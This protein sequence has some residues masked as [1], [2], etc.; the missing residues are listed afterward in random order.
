MITYLTTLPSPVGTLTL[1]AD[2]TALTGLW[3]EGQKYFGAGLPDTIQEKDLSVFRE[4]EA[5]LKAYFAKAPLP[6]LPPLAP[7]GSSFRQA[8]WQLLLEI[9]YGTVTTYGALAQKLRDRGISA[10]AQAVGGAVGHNPISILIPCHRVVG[11]DGQP[12]R[13]TPAV[14]PRKQLL[15]ELEGVDMAGLYVPTRGTAL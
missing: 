4:A 10:A 9:P 3:L 13:A 6:A 11:S 7:Q 2:G 12:D 1:A 15:L 8:V 14:L 5:W